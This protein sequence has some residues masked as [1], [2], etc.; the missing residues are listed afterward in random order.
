[1]LKEEARIDILI[2]NAGIAA[3]PYSLTE[4]GFELQFGVNHLGHF[5]LTN[6]LLDRIK[7]G[8]A[9][10]IVTVSSMGHTFG[11]INFDDLQSKQSYSRMGAYGQSKL[12]SI[13][14][15][16]SLAKK[17]KGSNVTAYCLHP[18]SVITD[19][20]RHVPAPVVSVL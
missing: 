17:L 3:P 10:R 16:Q 9:G 1:M 7:E 19:L 14:F 12:A 20:G 5:L 11:K 4:D 6:L 13:L 15:T 18:G 8:P 2:N